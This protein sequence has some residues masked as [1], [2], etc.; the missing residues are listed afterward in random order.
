MEKLCP[1]AFWKTLSVWITQRSVELE[2]PMTVL[3]S[4]DSRQTISL[5]LGRKGT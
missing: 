2:V 3:F 1:V 5:T 4:F